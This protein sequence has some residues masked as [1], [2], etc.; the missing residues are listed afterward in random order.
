VF[1]FDAVQASLKNHSTELGDSTNPRVYE[2][3]DWSQPQCRTIPIQ[4]PHQV[5]DL[6]SFPVH[7]YRLEFKRMDGKS[8]ETNWSAYKR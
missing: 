4:A 7:F 3:S 8:I 2:D 5:T 6:D 1:A